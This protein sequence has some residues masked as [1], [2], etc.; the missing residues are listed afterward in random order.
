M[1]TSRRSLIRDTLLIASVALVTSLFASG[2]HRQATQVQYAPASGQVVASP[3]GGV[4]TLHITNA[5]N[6]PIF[7]IYMSP[8]TQST[9]GQD[10]LGSSVL[11][12][13]QTFT[14]SNI[15]PGGW[16]LRVVDQSGNSKEWRNQMFDA[17]GVYTIDVSSSG[18]SAP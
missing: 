8:V 3:G 10:L 17:G 6:E 9:W 16:D 12:V 15:A 1:H 4:A 11:A 5:S 18:W 14:I 13:G 2:C 7:Y